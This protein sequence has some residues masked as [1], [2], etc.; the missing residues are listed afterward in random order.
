MKM[1]ETT[2]IM[3]LQDGSGLSYGVEEVWLQ[4]PHGGTLAGA[5][6]HRVL[7]GERGGE[8][9]GP[10]VRRRNAFA[11]LSLRLWR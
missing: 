11:H 5:R 4:D 8:G 7:H 3:K 1:I 9:G 10:L 2:L 6:G